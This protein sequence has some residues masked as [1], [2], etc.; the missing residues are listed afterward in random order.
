[1]FQVLRELELY[2]I[3]VAF[4]ERDG[5]VLAAGIGQQHQTD[6]LSKG[7]AI[8]L[9]G[10]AVNTWNAIG[11][12]WSL[13]VRD[14]SQLYYNQEILLQNVSISSLIVMHQLTYLASR[15]DKGKFLD[16]LH[17]ALDAI[18]PYGCCIIGGTSM[19]GLDWRQSVA[20]LME[21]RRLT[22]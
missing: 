16:E 21:C 1:M 12:Q 2:Q 3:S 8:V 11:E 6:N 20:A 19:L 15:D 5:I 9:R 17:Q 14:L 7:I 13:G 10:P 22:M 18:P 4:I